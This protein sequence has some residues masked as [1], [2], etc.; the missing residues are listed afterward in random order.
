MMRSWGVPDPGEEAVHKVRLGAAQPTG[1]CQGVYTP[2]EL[3]AE[4][5]FKPGGAVLSRT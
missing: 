1:R 2:R 5:S 3:P 4:S